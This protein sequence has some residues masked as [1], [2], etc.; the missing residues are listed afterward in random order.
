MKNVSRFLA[1]V[2]L[3][4][5]MALLTLTPPR[6][7]ATD[8]VTTAPSTATTAPGT[9]GGVA[10]P[11][12][13]SPPAE[14]APPAYEVVENLTDR[15]SGDVIVKVPFPYPDSSD[16]PSLDGEDIILARSVGLCERVQGSPPTHRGTCQQSPGQYSPWT[17]PVSYL[18]VMDNKGGTRRF[19]W[20]C[21]MTREVSRCVKGTTR[22]RFRI[23]PDR[24]FQ[25]QCMK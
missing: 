4:G 22:V 16:A 19:M 7:A 13:S 24:R 3:C 21:N 23:G 1:A 15:C 14:P 10:P 2:A 12:V 11:E 17:K 6:S 8:A 25:T 18:S 5:L 9:A 20:F